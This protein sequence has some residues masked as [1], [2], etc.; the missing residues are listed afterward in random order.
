[1]AE[2]LKSGQE[3]PLTED[4]WQDCAAS[5]D[6]P[7]PPATAQPPDLRACTKSARPHI[8]VGVQ[9]NDVTDRAPDSA[10]VMIFNVSGR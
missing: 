10:I 6:Q 8:T 1:M 7:D 3:K 5:G 9:P 2:S 4:V